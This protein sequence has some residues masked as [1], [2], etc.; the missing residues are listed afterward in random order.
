MHDLI[1][2]WRAGD[3]KGIGQFAMSKPTSSATANARILSAGPRH[4]FLCLG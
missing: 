3:P 1:A 2:D 4:L